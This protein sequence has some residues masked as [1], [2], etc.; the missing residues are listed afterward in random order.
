MNDATPTR[1]TAAGHLVPVWWLVLMAA[2][3]AAANNA[4]VLI[5]DDVGAAFGTSA[6]SA[7]W[8]AT[9]FALVL[10]VAT[11]LQA[12]LMRHRGQLAVL[13][14]SAALVTLGSLVVLL[15][16]WLPLIV[17]GRAI[18][19]AGGAGLNVLA[20]GLAGSA[21]RVGAISTGMGL[22]GAVGPL[23]GTQ[24]ST[25][26]SW[27]LVLVLLALALIAVPFVHRYVA[28]GAVSNARFDAWGALLVVVLSGAVVLFTANPLTA[29]LAA[30]IAILLLMF[31]I[32]R[33]PDG[34]V[35]VETIRSR[36]FLNS[37][38]L[39]LTLSASYFTLLFVIP[40]LLITRADWTKDTAATGQLVAMVVA[41]LA[42]LGFTA[43]A[44]KFSRTQVRIVL[45]TAGALALLAAFFA[46]SPVLLLI[47]IFLA[48]FAAISA[49]ATQVAVA[50]SAVPETQ[51]PVAIGLFTLLY[52]LGGAIGP[53]L[54]SILVLS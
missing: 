45:V 5:L 18:Q 33:R 30:M 52:L 53:A 44:A 7:S 39:T 51:K 35:P 22:L 37:A 11:P 34:Y 36:V 26:V 46:S 42:T 40:Q 32:R 25:A 13:W 2:P 28:R 12:A 50:T 16:P 19:A 17:A 24:L 54:A 6:A 21:R 20:I 29:A 10:A 31:H 15:A 49:N 48:L 9:A 8:A 14:T 27:R 38:G 4:T 23:L 1:S 3:V 47:G 41:S 43:V